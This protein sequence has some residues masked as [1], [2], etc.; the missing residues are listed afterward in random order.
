[1]PLDPFPGQTLFTVN[2][3]MYHSHTCPDGTVL[4]FIWDGT[5]D[6]ANNDKHDTAFAEAG[7][8]ARPGMIIR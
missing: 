2:Q 3:G 8:T 4:H 7:A 1:M 6:E 5:K